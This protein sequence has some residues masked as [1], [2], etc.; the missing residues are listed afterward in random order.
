MNLR[1]LFQPKPSLSGSEVSRGLRFMTWEGM[2]SNGFN[3]ITSSGFLA[4]FALILGA[5]A[6]QIGLLAA[7]PFV[8]QFGQLPSILLLEKFRRRKILAVSTWFL[9][10]LIWFPIALIPLLLK[11][12]GAPAV[13]LLLVLVTLRGILM[14]VTN[15]SWNS[16]ARDLVPQHLLGRYFSRRQALSTAVAAVF[17]I[18]AAFFVEYWHLIAPGSDTAL[19]YTF[20]ILA[21]ALFLGMASPVLMSLQPEPLMQA[22]IDR[23]AS[24]FNVIS[25][26]LKEKN[27][28]RFLI[29][30]FLWNLALNLAVPFLAV[31]MLK[32]L[33]L[34][35]TFVIGFSV[36]G[37]VFSIIFLRVW[38]PLADRFGSKVVLSL[39]AS[40]YLLVIFG[41][42][43]AGNPE[44]YFLTI[45]LLAVLSAFG[46]IASAGVS[47]TIATLGF[48]LA[49]RDRAASFLTSASLATNLGSGIG[50]LLGGALAGYFSSRR[51]NFDLTWISPS[52]TLNLGMISLGGYDF[53]FIITVIV[54]LIVLN[55]LVTIHEEGETRRDVVLRELREKAR[56]TFHS[57]VP[58][59]RSYILDGISFNILSRVPGMDVAIGVTAYQLAN[60]A[61]MITDAA[62]AGGRTTVRVTGEIQDWLGRLWAT[63]QVPLEQNSEVARQ[64]ARGVLLAAGAGSAANHELAGQAMVGIVSAMQKAHVDPYEAIRGAAYGVIEGADET[65]AD[66]GHATLEVLAGTRQSAK[67]F[68]LDTDLAT[69]HAVRGITSAAEKL[70]AGASKQVEETIKKL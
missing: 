57:A 8:L 35:L 3:S 51:L 2:A 64:A 7:I 40:L 29:F 67:D 32:Q 50:P 69:D 16:W 14:S 39:S 33:G 47:L 26:P 65:G 10:Q 13:S 15:C 1:S 59:N 61:K 22:S 25:H 52:H 53:L 48:K 44:R 46:G 56:S 23:Q 6:F 55:M 21:G 70:G 31:F 28:R 41:W 30:L 18:G 36:V 37:Q 54:G 4:A 60:T 38:G 24:L 62:L 34:P 63:G 66:I 27:F 12:P 9:A 17:G 11:T 45:P 58:L 19:G 68:N 42:T 49:P 43:F 5:S 20:A